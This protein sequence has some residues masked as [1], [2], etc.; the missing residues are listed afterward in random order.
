MLIMI[1][2]YFMA[3]ALCVCVWEMYACSLW[4]ENYHYKLQISILR[5]M[6]RTSH[7]TY[8]NPQS[9]DRYIFPFCLRAGKGSILQNRAF[10]VKLW[11]VFY[12]STN[13]SA[14]LNIMRSRKSFAVGGIIPAWPLTHMQKEHRLHTIPHVWRYWQHGKAWFFT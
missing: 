8:K 3:G 6:S 4:T 12:P 5:I 9:E 11:H 14:V 10:P 2:K 1:H 13:I 7:W